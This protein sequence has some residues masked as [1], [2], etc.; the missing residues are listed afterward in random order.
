MVQLLDFFLFM[1]AFQ[2]DLFLLL[3][4]EVVTARL[5]VHQAA[6]RVSDPEKR[7]AKG[8]EAE[9]HPADALDELRRD[10]GGGLGPLAGPLCLM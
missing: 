7:A 4:H 10:D 6:Q 2:S 8:V 1:R 9:E 3:R 5:P